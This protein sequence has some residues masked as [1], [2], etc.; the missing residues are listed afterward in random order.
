[1]KTKKH[2][3][4]MNLQHVDNKPDEIEKYYNEC[5]NKHGKVQNVLKENS[6]K[7]DKLKEINGL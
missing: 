6:F 3:T 7:I 2:T 5:Q 4:T 1:M